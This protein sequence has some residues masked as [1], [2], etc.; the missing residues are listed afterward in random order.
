M[1]LRGSRNKEVGGRRV[2]GGNDINIVLIF[3]ILYK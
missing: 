1:N 2:L 3:E